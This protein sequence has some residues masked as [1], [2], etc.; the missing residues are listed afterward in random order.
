MLALA[1]CGPLQCMICY[2]NGGVCTTPTSLPTA[3]NAEHFCQ[4]PRQPVAPG[5]GVLRL[6][7]VMLPPALPPLPSCTS[8]S[9]ASSVR[10]LHPQWQVV[11]PHLLQEPCHAQQTPLLQ[12]AQPATAQNRQSYAASAVQMLCQTGTVHRAAATSTDSALGPAGKHGPQASLATHQLHNTER[13]LYVS[14]MEQP[15]PQKT[16]AVAGHGSIK[17]V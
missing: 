12:V 4:H 16:A 5:G 7:T 11:G 3:C 6:S 14:T 1:A 17:N 10:A 15:L 2:Q 8:A 13:D 9:T